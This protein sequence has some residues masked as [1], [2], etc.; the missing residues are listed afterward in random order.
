VGEEEI[1]RWRLRPTGFATCIRG[2]DNKSRTIEQRALVE[3]PRPLLVDTVIDGTGPLIMSMR[4]RTGSHSAPTH[5][6]AYPSAPSLTRTTLRRFIL[7]PRNLL[8]PSVRLKTALYALSLLVIGLIFLALNAANLSSSTHVSLGDGT[9]N[10][11]PA[12]AGLADT[13]AAKTV[14]Q[15]QDGA[16]VKEEI[17]RSFE[18]PDFAL[19]SGKQPS[20]RG[21]DV[22]LAGEA[23]GQNEGK[24]V[25]LGIFSAADKKERR[26]L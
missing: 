9:Y 19:L 15:G 22:P 17:S 14:A 12:E 16:E 4:P 23:G 18:E 2:N 26:D 13:G 6:L 5:S 11:I 8:L 20:E 21:C 25:F 24:L 1:R 7:S 3:R 10:T